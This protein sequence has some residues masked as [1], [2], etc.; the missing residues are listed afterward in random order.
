M[1][2][3][4]PSLSIYAKMGLEQ[5]QQ[6]LESGVGA[7]FRE[8]HVFPQKLWLLRESRMEGCLT[9]SYLKLKEDDSPFRYGCGHMRYILLYE[10]E[11]MK[12]K[13][14]SGFS[15]AAIKEQFV[16]TKRIVFMN[17]DSVKEEKYSEIY[18]SLLD[19]IGERQFSIDDYLT[20]SLQESS[21]NQHYICISSASRV[22]A[23]LEQCD[24]EEQVETLIQTA[25]EVVSKLE[26]KAQTE[27]PITRDSIGDGSAVILNTP[28]LYQAE[29]ADQWI[30]R[31][32]SDPLTREW[33]QPNTVLRTNVCQN[34]R[35][36]SERLKEVIAQKRR[37]PVEEESPSSKKPH[38]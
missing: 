21:R 16:D 14:I 7:R 2:M 28:H 11:E 32:G 24:E 27:C 4:G 26:E 29:A 10:G 30:A 18:K 19:I 5:V 3:L 9:L 17:M 31:A 12:W 36:E 6:K 22:R 25:E 13:C 23:E 15:E 1:S 35:K 34:A 37:N 33:I 38:I 20:P 8:T